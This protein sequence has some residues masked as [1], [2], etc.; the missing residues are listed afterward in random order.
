MQ[1]E[2]SKLEP[3]LGVVLAYGG[4]RPDEFGSY[5]LVWQGTNDASVFIFLHQQ[6]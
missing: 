5:G 6:S 4:E 1:A 3:M 2:M